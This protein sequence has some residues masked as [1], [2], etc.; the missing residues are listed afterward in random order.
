MRQSLNIKHNHM[1]EK[2]QKFVSDC[3]LMS[4]RAA[5]REIE[6][7]YFAINGTKAKLGDRVNPAKDRVTYKGKPVKPSGG[8]K[9]YILLHK[10]AGVVT[11]M[12]DEFGRRTVAEL[13]KGLG[14]RVYP[15]GRLDKDSEGLLLMTDDGT[16]ANRIAHPSGNIRKVYHVMLA[17]RV[18]NN[19]LDSLRAMRKLDDEPIVPVQVDLIERNDNASKVKFVLS[20]GKNRQIR[21]MCEA[22]G[23]S[24]M[25]LK[26]VQ[27]GNLLLGG[28]ESG[29]YRHLTDEERKGLSKLLSGEKQHG[30]NDVRAT[31]GSAGTNRKRTGRR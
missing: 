20:E 16:F 13:V 27:L 4:R 6:C 1:D 3:G 12:N 18:E 24:V 26:R 31:A 2:L 28:L 10:P 8:R 19:Q 29:A 25:Q 30:R 23:L 11:T 5:E 15:V 22:V 14:K 17:G 9:V 21:R 7:G